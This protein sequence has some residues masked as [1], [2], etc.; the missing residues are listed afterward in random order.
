[1]RVISCVGDGPHWRGN[2]GRFQTGTS[3]HDTLGFNC[4]IIHGVGRSSASESH[5]VTR[6]RWKRSAWR[7]K[8]RLFATF[9]NGL[10]KYPHGRFSVACPFPVPVTVLTCLRPAGRLLQ[11]LKRGQA[12]NATWIIVRG[13]PNGSFDIFLGFGMYIIKDRFYYDLD[14]CKIPSS[15]LERVNFVDAAS[16]LLVLGSFSTSTILCG[17]CRGEISRNT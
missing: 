12:P 10:G 15:A 11:G 5:G 6:R 14:Q 3:S 8:L 16:D 7:R 9:I 1:M 2:V 17:L 4:T 13:L